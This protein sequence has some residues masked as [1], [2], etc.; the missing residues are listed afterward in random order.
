VAIDPR[1]RQKKLERRKAKD[2]SR[3]KALAVSQLRRLA[4]QS[5]QASSGEILDCLVPKTLWDE[6]IGNILFSRELDAGRVAHATFLIDTF[7]LGVKDAAFFVSPRDEYDHVIRDRLISRFE[8][9][10]RSPAFVRKLVEESIIYARSLGF[11]PHPD[12]QQAK[13]IFGDVDANA[14]REVFAFGKDGKP[15]LIS[16]LNDSPQ[17]CARIVMTLTERCGAGGF[18]YL[19]HFPQSKLAAAGLSRFGLTSAREDA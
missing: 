1:K 11:E 10:T 18:D 3:D 16:G 2:K 14:C 4:I 8:Y 13:A 19:L 9:Q 6:G 17:R 5:A 12:Y 15:F 7:C